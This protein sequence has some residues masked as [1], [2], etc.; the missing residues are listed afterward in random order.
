MGIVVDLTHLEPKA[1]YEALDETSRPAIVSHCAAA[2]VTTDLPDDMI[3]GV[4]EGGG[5]LGLHFYRTYLLQPSARFDAGAEP[6]VADLLDQVDYLAALVGIDYIGLGGDFFPR[7]GRWREFQQAQG[8]QR[9]SWAI[10]DLGHLPAVLSAMDERG[11]SKGEIAKMAG[12]NF[13]RVCSEVFG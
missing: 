4:A 1:F 10:P 6:S 5:V 9:M 13:L 12:E 8:V 2:G 3:R 7:S 11:Y